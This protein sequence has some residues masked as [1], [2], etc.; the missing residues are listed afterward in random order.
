MLH[1]PEMEVVALSAAELEDLASALKSNKLSTGD[2][3][4]PPC[5]KIGVPLT[6]MPAGAGFTAPTQPCAGRPTN[7]SHDGDF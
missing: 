3:V 1:Q 6:S 2:G 5:V 7:F 4:V